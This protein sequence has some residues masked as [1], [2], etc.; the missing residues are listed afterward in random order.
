MWCSVRS[1]ADPGVVAGR[2]GWLLFTLGWLLLP[3]LA[4]LWV[5]PPAPRLLDGQPGLIWQEP[6]RCWSAAWVHWTPLHLG[7]NA[8]GTL[9]LAA[10]GVVARVPLRAV[11]AWALSWPLVAPAVALLQPALAHYGGLS[12]VLHGG[13]AIVIVWLLR[14]PAAGRRERVVGGLLLLGLLLKLLGERFWTLELRQGGGWDF[15]VVPLAHALGAACGA[16]AGWWCLP[17]R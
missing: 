14:Q 15:A 3:S 9:L 12:G 2:R 11:C 5:G 10:L 17:R 8:A 7:A 4:V 13:V 1:E 6:W 16:L